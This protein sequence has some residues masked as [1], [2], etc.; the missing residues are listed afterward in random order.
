MTIARI[1]FLS[2]G[3]CGVSLKGGTRKL[4]IGN[5]EI[6]NSTDILYTVYRLIL[7]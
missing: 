3:I 5:M 7:L 4:E 1:S 2:A 6:G